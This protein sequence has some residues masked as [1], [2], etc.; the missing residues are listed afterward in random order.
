MGGRGPQRGGLRLAQRGGPGGPA[1]GGVVTSPV[2]SSIPPLLS[3]CRLLANW[4][5]LL[6]RTA[7]RT[8]RRT[9]VQSCAKLLMHFGIPTVT[10]C[11]NDGVVSAAGGGGERK[12]EDA[13]G[14]RWS[15]SEETER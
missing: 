12:A 3:R 6:T 1:L 7:W 8:R 10:L 9:F 4:G 11:A 2:A 15:S 13:K 14:G 5:G